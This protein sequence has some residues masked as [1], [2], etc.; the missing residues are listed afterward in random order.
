MAS[1][2]NTIRGFLLGWLD[3][4]SSYS[5]HL[6]LASDPQQLVDRL[7]LTMTGQ[8]MT[9][10]NLALVRDTVANSV[11]ASTPIE[12]VRM[13]AFLIMVSPDYLVQK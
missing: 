5:Q 10:E 4:Q 13:A 9:P 3:A 7:N 11:P 12:R 6:S 1:T 8:Q 2:I